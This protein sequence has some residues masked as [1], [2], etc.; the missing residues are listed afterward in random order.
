MHIIEIGLLLHLQYQY[1]IKLFKVSFTSWQLEDYKKL[2]D[3][4]Y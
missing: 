2:Q 1:S 3:I 4:E